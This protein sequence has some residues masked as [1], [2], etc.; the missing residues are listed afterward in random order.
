MKRMHINVGVENLDKSIKFYSAL[1]GEQPAKIKS[2]YAKWM[3][4]DP[5][6]NFAI[7][8]R[9]G[10]QGVDHLG[11]Q[12]EED[13]ELEELRARFKSADMSV[14]DEGETVCCY[15]RSDKTWVKDPSGIA[16][17]AY[18]NMEDVQLFGSSSTAQEGAC[19]P[20]E[21]EVLPDI[22]EVT[23]KTTACCK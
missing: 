1:F 9:T 14:F 12:V 5:R 16:W 15:A 10:R 20:P 2:D 7:T 18:K 23:E 21:T 19:C 17:E 11:L 6:I 4:D 8:T 3:V 22:P 13:S